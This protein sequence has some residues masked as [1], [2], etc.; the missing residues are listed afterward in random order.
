MLHCVQD[1]IHSFDSN[2]DFTI[3]AATEPEHWLEQQLAYEKEL[4]DKSEEMRILHERIQE[5]ESASLRGGISADW[6]NPMGQATGILRLK[7]ELAQRHRLL[8][9][10]EAHMVEQMRELEVT[11]AT[12]RV[13]I[14]RQR[15]TVERMKDEL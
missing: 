8:K 3:Q 12:E 11:I 15:Q 6:E 7:R 10:A 2:A 4:Q 13:E 1:T 5:L 14:A 9:Q